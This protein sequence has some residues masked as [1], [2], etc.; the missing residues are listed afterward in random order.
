MAEA[1]ITSTGP[2]GDGTSTGMLGQ[3][4]RSGQSAMESEEIAGDARRLRQICRY[5]L[6]VWI[7]FYACDLVL[8]FVVYHGSALA[9]AISRIVGVVLIAGVA[10]WMARRPPKTRAGITGVVAVLGFSVTAILGF[11]AALL[12]GL[13]SPYFFGP[14]FPIA[15]FGLMQRRLSDS[16]YALLAA[17]CGYPAGLCLGSAAVR[18]A[19]ATTEGAVIFA[20]QMTLLLALAGFAGVLSHY[21]W[22]L[23]RAL[24]ESRSIGR[25][26]LKRRLGRGA[27]GEV[28]AAFHTTLRRDVAV[29]I[30]RPERTDDAAVQRFEREVRATSELTHPNTVRVFDYGVSE[31]GLWYFAMELLEGTTLTNLVKSQGPLSPARAVHFMTQA[32][33]AVAEAH[34][35]G[36]VHR[37]LKPD[38]LFVVVAGGERDF[39]K[40]IDFGI[41]RQDGEGGGFHESGTQVGHVA[42]TP[43]FMAPEVALGRRAD[44]RA[45]VYALGAVLYYLLVGSP[46]FSAAG[47]P[48]MLMAHVHDPVV[49]PSVRMDRPLAADLE[50][51]VLRCLEKRPDLRY[52]DA[53]ALAEALAVCSLFGAWQPRSAPSYP[54]LVAAHAEDTLSSPQITALE[55]PVRS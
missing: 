14:A 2:V 20:A 47:A 13:A 54:E 40:V 36:I 4:P 31:D 11:H 41:A 38:N 18:S 3:A 45:D 19:L 48:A 17:A 16:I 9:L 44:A 5:A 34:R 12:G 35:H 52:A 33:R 8:S 15:G 21:G 43:A 23:R 55:R 25:Y 51:I 46:P 42:G 6:P 1:T 37:D 26:Q 28:W 49:P 39:L 32:A 50:A 53:G 29:K 24:F 27:M 30:L 10:L 7:A 22:T